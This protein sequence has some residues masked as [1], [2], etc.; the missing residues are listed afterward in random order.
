MRLG[1]VTSVIFQSRGGGKTTTLMEEIHEYGVQ[2]RMTEVLVVCS[3]RGEAD[4]WMRR[5]RDKYPALRPPRI[6]TMNNL[7]P[8]R[9]L[10]FEKI[11]FENIE[12]DLEGIYSERVRDVLVTLVEAREPEVV[13]TCSPL[14]FYYDWPY[15]P[16]PTEEE[17]A[18]IA[19]QEA[20]EE[21]RRRDN[22]MLAYMRTKILHWKNE[23]QG[24]EDQESAG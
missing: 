3:T 20:A 2:N 11:Y 16:E 22:F 10:R 13:F 23:R 19:A 12:I 7:L 15:D 9:G 17:L 8:I 21:K 18:E 5:W 14:D 24:E 4:L 6:I 1:E